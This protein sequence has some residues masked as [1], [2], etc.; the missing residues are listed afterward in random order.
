[1][2]RLVGDLPHNQIY[3]ARSM[4]SPDDLV[5]WRSYEDRE[6][7]LPWVPRLV[8][9][10]QHVR[11][12]CLLYLR[13]LGTVVAHRNIFANEDARLE[14][15]QRS[16]L[17]PTWNS[18]NSEGSRMPSLLVS[19]SLNIRLRAL[20]QDGFNTWYLDENDSE[21]MWYWWTYMIPRVVKRGCWVKDSLLRE[22]KYFWHV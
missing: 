3:G 9:R 16:W 17:S 4:W 15:A 8:R 13:V 19:Q 14:I 12:P 20:T 10:L 7:P 2:L 5:V 22:I 21:R 1:M 6:T 18:F 11:G